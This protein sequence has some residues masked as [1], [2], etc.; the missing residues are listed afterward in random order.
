MLCNNI[1][2]MDSK[3]VGRYEYYATRQQSRLYCSGI[4]DNSVQTNEEIPISNQIKNSSI[5]YD[6]LLYNVATEHGIKVVGVEG[7]SLPHNKESPGYNST[8]EA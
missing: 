4:K 1:V 7:K 2:F 3:R 8:R 5:Y 6:A